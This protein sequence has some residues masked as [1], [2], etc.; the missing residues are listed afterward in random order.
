MRIFLA[1]GSGAVGKRLIPMLAAAGHQVTATTRLARKTSDLKLLGTERPVVMDGLNRGEVLNS[2][3]TARPDV[4]IHEMTALSSFKNYKD[5]DHELAVTNR[6]RTE[7]TEHLLEAA[8]QAG[9]TKFIAQS[10]SGWPN[11]RTGSKIKT[12]EDPLDPNPP[13]K[14]AR[15]LEAIKRQEELVTSANGLILRYGSFY[16][17]GTSISRDG[18]VVQILRQGKLPLI[19]NGHGVWS[20]LHIDDAARATK[21]AMELDAKGIYNI[22]D[23]EPAEVRVWLPELAD[24]VG[25]KPPKWIPAWLASFSVGETGVSI[26]TKVRGSS[27]EKAKRELGWHPQFASWRDGFRRGLG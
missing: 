15:T 14:M 16:G 26:M 1:G 8:R 27:N 13:K 25:T 24:A 20:F 7:G 23:D 10:Y 21:L 11:A 9:V 12:E 6:L 4:I 19:G 18:D 5:I 2:V 3:L 17:P 22:V